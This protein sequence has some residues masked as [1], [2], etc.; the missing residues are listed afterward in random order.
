MPKKN[1]RI[2][3]ALDV[4]SSSTG[5]AVFKN[6]RWSKAKNSFGLIKTSS[7]MSLGERLCKFRNEVEELIDRVKPTHIVIEDVFSGRNVKT[8]KLLARFNGVAV[9]LS[10]R[11][12]DTEPLIV[13]TASVRKFLKCGKSKEE[14]FA[15]ICDR[16]N[17]EW[18]FKKTNDITDA[19]SLALYLHGNIEE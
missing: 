6:G 7:S 8:M 12:T 2:L 10:K 15:Y 13:L 5:Y 4:S 19:I 11:K 1:N 16:Y 3:L 18:E 17:L 14:A 9:E